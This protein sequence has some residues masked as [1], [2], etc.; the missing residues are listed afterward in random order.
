MV[1]LEHGGNR[2]TLADRL[3]TLGINIIQATIISKRV[4]YT[5]KRYLDREG[6][7]ATQE[8]S[9]QLNKLG[10]SQDRLWWGPMTLYPRKAQFLLGEIERTP[11]KRLLEV[12]GGTSTSLFA[13][14][15][16]KHNFTVLSLDNHIGTIN[17]IQSALENLPCGNHVRLQQCGFVRRRYQNGEKYR[18]YDAILDNQQGQ[19]DFV[20]IDGPMGRLVGRNGALPEIRPY[21]AKDHRIY[22]D[23]YNREH[24]KACVSEWKRHYPDLV[25]ETFEECRGIARL[26]LPGI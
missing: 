13:A 9:D 8:F 2:G 21:L 24:E 22:L 26:R 10:L 25:V 23:D 1:T 11:P 19:Y 7:R 16:L 3:F 18:W 20:F 5:A 15:A 12:G 6:P 4:A 14:L 17:Y